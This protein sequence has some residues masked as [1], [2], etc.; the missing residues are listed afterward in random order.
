MRANSFEI[1]TVFLSAAA[2]AFVLFSV[3]YYSI[4][5]FA[6]S[7][8]AYMKNLRTNHR[9]REEDII[10]FVERFLNL[11]GSLPLLSR[12]ASA[13]LKR[14]WFSSALEAAVQKCYLSV[15]PLESFSVLSNSEDNN[16]AEVFSL[17]ASSIESGS[18]ST[19]ELHAMLGRIKPSVMSKLQ[20]LPKV[21]S[22]HSICAISSAVF[23]PIFAG[24]GT[25]IISFTGS[26]LG[27]ASIASF[28][29]VA[30]IS[31][32]FASIFL[33]S[34]AN[35]PEASASK[36]SVMLAAAMLVFRASSMLSAQYVI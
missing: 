5:M 7:A 13:N 25:T 1:A 33:Y 29:A 35:A 17:I 16:V 10:E 14:F 26:M 19:K 28:S 22:A 32:I 20:I 2:S 31:Y 24:I 15:R 23:F 34:M 11:S 4:P 27:S 6:F 9:K 21:Q 30:F 12:V 36:V 3:F 18:D 8:I